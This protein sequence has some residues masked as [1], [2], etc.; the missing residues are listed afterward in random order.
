MLDRVT[1][2]CHALFKKMC[3]GDETQKCVT[4]RLSDKLLLELL[5]Q[6]VNSASVMVDESG[7]E[8]RRDVVVI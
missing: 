2:E 5:S 8:E 4:D 6:P 7:M 1:N 3:V